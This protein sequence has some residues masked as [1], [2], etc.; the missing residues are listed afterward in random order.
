MC[1]CKLNV[2]LCIAAAG[3]QRT[4]EF[5]TSRWVHVIGGLPI[6][7]AGPVQ[8]SPYNPLP[9]GTAGKGSVLTG[10]KLLAKH[11]E[12]PDIMT[13][14]FDAPV[15]TDGKS[16]CEAGQFASF[17]FPG[18][19]PGETLNRTW[20]ISSHPDQIA[21]TGKF[22]ISVKKV[23]LSHDIMLPKIFSSSCGMMHLD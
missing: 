1:T 12:T 17:D 18:L 16:F 22:T 14:V 21:A 4:L 2:N 20:T 6:S 8:L 13:F 7:T 11:R 15:R 10:L 5:V 9:P 23:S 3:A 19:K